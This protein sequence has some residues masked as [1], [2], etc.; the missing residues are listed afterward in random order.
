MV[1]G[2]NVRVCGSPGWVTARGHPVF[3]RRSAPLR[4]T[5][6]FFRPSGKANVGQ[7][8]IGQRNGDKGMMKTGAGCPPPFL[9]PLPYIPLPLL[10]ASG[11][12]LSRLDL[13]RLAA[14]RNRPSRG[15]SQCA[16]VA[17]FRTAKGP[18][19]F[20]LAG[21]VIVYTA[22]ANQETLE[23]SRLGFGPG[24]GLCKMQPRFF[25][26]RTRPSS[27]PVRSV[28]TLLHGSPPHR[29]LANSATGMLHGTAATGLAVSRAAWR[30]M[31]RS[32]RSAT[33]LVGNWS[34]IGRVFRMK[35]PAPWGYSASIRPD[36]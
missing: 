31:L 16:C 3:F 20:R 1:I 19:N 4:E 29:I 34:R 17:L 14:R 10:R 11:R 33:G 9:I 21:G 22:H 6:F 23:P 32:R 13:S 25:S 30:S 5:I 24:F 8:D 35:R 28:P 2:S 36:E 27:R 18:S 26:R 7:R 12:R 15:T